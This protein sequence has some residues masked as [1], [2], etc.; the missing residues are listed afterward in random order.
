MKLVITV[1]RP[2]VYVKKGEEALISGARKGKRAW[3]KLAPTCLS[4]L[5]KVGKRSK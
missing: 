3:G 1:E 5:R 2:S 4:Y